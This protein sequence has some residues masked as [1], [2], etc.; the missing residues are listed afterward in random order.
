MNQD[1]LQ[2]K[3]KGYCCSQIIMAMGL[4]KLGKEN[5]DL[6]QA[7]AGLCNGV[8]QE[9]ICGTLSA[10]VCLLCLADPH[11]AGKT[12]I[13]ELVDWFEASFGNTECSAL[14]NGNPLAKTETCPMIIEATFTKISEM[15][16]W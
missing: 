1:I 16:D 7:T 14:I 6:I 10:G 11:E 15:L 2:Y 13:S 12:Y 4:E 8:W 5:P 9:K 3:L